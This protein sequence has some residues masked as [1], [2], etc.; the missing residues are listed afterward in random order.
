MDVITGVA[1]KVGASTKFG[2]EE[3]QPWGLA[4]SKKDGIS[5]LHMVGSA[6]DG[7]GETNNA[8]LYTLNTSTGSATRVGEADDFGSGGDYSPTGLSWHKDTLYMLGQQYPSLYGLSR[9]DGNAQFNKGAYDFHVSETLPAGLASVDDKLYMTG[10]TNKVLY[11]VDI[12]SSLAV[13]VSNAEKFGVGEDLPAGIAPGYDPSDFAVSSTGAITYNGAAQSGGTTLFFLATATDGEHEDTAVVKVTVTTPDAASLTPVPSA[14]TVGAE[15]TEFTLTTNVSAGIKVEVTQDTGTVALA[16]ASG[17]PSCSGALDIE[18]D[19]S[20]G[21]KVK[22]AGCTEGSATVKLLKDT[23]ELASYTVAVSRPNTTSLPPDTASLSSEPS[24]FTVGAEATEF[25]LTTNVSAGIKVEV[26]QGTGTVALSAASSTPLCSGTLNVEED[27]SN[28]GKVKMVGC[29]A[30][31]ATVKLLKDTTELTSYTVAVSPP[32]TASLSP[33]PSAF[34]MG[35]EATEFTLTTNVSAGIKVKVTQGTGTVAI[36]ACSGTLDIEEDVTNGGKVKMVGCTAGSATVKLLKDTT[37]LASYAVAVSPPDTASL[38]PVPSAFTVGAAAAK[39]TLT[40]N[41]SA[42]IKVKVTQ[43]TDSVA[44]SA[45]SGTP[46]CGGTLD[47]EED[48]SNGGKVKMVGCTEGTATVKL[49][50]DTTELASYTVAVSPPDTASLSPVP[51]ALTVG[52]AATEF[53][54]TTNVSTS[55]KVKVTQDTDSVALSAASSTPLCSGTLNVEEDVSNGGKVK[56]VGC[57]VGSATVKLLKDT[58]ELTSYTVAVSP[59]DTA[60]LSPEPSAFTMGAE[61]TEF[62]LTTNVSAGIKVKVTQGTGTVAISACSGTLDIEEDVT[63]GGMVK[64][65]GCTAG[66]A[67]VKLLKDTTELASYTVAVSPPDTASL[68]PEPSAFT[69]GAEA[70]EF[71][72]TTNVSAGIKVKVTQATDSVA[73]SAYSGT[74]SCSDTLDIEEDLGNGD[75]VKIAGC[76]EGSATVKLLKDTTELASYTVA[77]SPLETASLSPVPSALTVGNTATEFTLT[78]NVSTS[79]KVKVTQDTGI[80]AM[81]AY[82][83]TPTCGGTLDI[84]EDVSNGDKVKMVGCTEGDATIKLLKDTTELASYTVTISPLETASLSPVPSALTVGNAA[85]EFT[86]TTNVS[87]SVK[88]KVTQDTG[89]VTLA[90]ASDTPSC[91]DTLDIEEDLGNGDKVKIAGC[92]EGDATIKLLKDTTELASYTVTISPLE[93]ASLSPVPSALTVGNAATEFTLTTNVSTSVKVKVTQDTGSVTLAAASDTP[94]CSDTLDIEEDLGN[95]DKVKIAGCTEGSATV[96]LLKDTTELASYTVAVS[97]PDTASLSPVPSTFTVGNAAAEFT[98]TTNVSAGIKV[99]VT[100]VTGTVALA[101]ASATP[102]CSDTLNV[103]EDLG[104]GGMVKIVGCTAGSATVKLLKDTTELASYTVAVSPPDTA[105]LSP[106]PST[107]TM[108]T[109]ATEFTLTTN[110]SAGIKV[111]VTQATDSVALSA[112]S[113][114]PSCIGTLNVEE[115]VSNGDKVKIAG[116]TEGSAT[117]K[118]LKDTTELASYTVAV[119]PPDTA[120]LSPEP[121]A[122]TMGNCR[123]GVHADHQCFDKREGKGHPG[124]RYRGNVCGRAVHRRVAVPWTSR[125][126]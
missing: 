15:A 116:C 20:N 111:K 13:R 78:T 6:S 5:T 40:T 93:T 61:A 118:L 75:K 11:Q 47:T 53:T 82:S 41:V 76:T 121:S 1:T 83:G 2:I 45:D 117:V 25:T 95:G 70:T 28:G 80:V 106:V 90:A 71:T 102:S 74:P 100:Q 94:S 36:S 101:E 126:T 34:T 122:F 124:Y 49:F 69:M 109:A 52:N 68:S 16:A 108:G 22:I 10:Q 21:D 96:K 26:T 81:S 54:L 67:T 63:N 62:T 59:P 39:F 125:R 79:V 51:S 104:N 88:V 19:V 32:D 91:S 43:V 64:I 37:K 48:V 110:V 58:T 115:D 114:T 103:E 17:T 113:S 38:T 123:D 99:K 56:M 3:D 84:E 24:A 57:T 89:S 46:S 12:A 31:S 14:F 60:S 77:V 35:A 50:K 27:V 29:T 8:A 66:S 30:G 73:L 23:T 33:E 7:G 4:S 86:L 119:S 18:E 87:T 97:P 92:T 44:L 105:S 85:T 107:F 65:V 72:L 42:G 120:S 55:V 98:L 112:A 9:S